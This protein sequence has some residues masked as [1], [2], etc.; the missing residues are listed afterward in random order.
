MTQLPVDKPAVKPSRRGAVISGLV[1][2]AVLAAVIIGVA[3][4]SPTDSEQPAPSIGLTTEPSAESVQLDATRR[5]G[6][7]GRG[8]PTAA[9]VACQPGASGRSDQPGGTRAAH[10]GDG[11]PEVRVRRA[12][13]ADHR[14]AAH[15]TARVTAV[16]PPATT[17][18]TASP[19]KVATWAS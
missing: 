10:Q 15:R 12:L 1:T 2:V 16:A 3:A 9:V 7:C 4:L 14:A 19:K 8:D 5:A 13:R 6:A 11:G 17:R 18:T